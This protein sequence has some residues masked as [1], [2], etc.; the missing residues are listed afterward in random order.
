MMTNDN[1]L[2]NHD[3]ENVP[4]FD[5][6]NVPF[7]FS[8]EKWYIFTSMIWRFCCVSNCEWKM[9]DGTFSRAKIMEVKMYLLRFFGVKSWKIWVKAPFLKTGFHPCKTLKNI[10]VAVFYG[11]FSRS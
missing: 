11:T 10:I 2:K 1:V 8:L 5:R 7:Y 3:R 6:E 9:V 4:G